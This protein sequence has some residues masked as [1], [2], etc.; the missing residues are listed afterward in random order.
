MHLGWV[1]SSL[2]TF[3]E[4]RHFDGTEKSKQFPC[5]MSTTNPWIH[6]APRFLLHY[7]PAKNLDQ[8]SV[9]VSLRFTSL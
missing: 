1:E 5:D 9:T 3:D 8:I 4:G 6:W 7:S 2:Y